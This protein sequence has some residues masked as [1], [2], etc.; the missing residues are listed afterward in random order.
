MAD[1]PVPRP[2]PTLVP[3]QLY[4][5]GR[6]I[7]RELT[8]RLA[9]LGLTLRL[10]GILGHLTRSPALSYSELARRADVSV[11]SMHGSV[12]PLIAEGIVEGSG[13][14]G[15]AAQL[16][17]TDA[18]RATLARAAAV[19]AAYEDEL[20]AAAGIPEQELRAAAQ[21]TLLATWRASGGGPDLP[22]PP[23]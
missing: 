1:D 15:Q 8:D 19:I 11:Q 14:A 13:T 16:S 4:A 6:L 3:F 7:E 18:G 5:A 17:I 20:L 2:I 22:G 21:S 10:V 9:A 23:P 12:R